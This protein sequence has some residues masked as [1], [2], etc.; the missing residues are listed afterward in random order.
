MIMTDRLQTANLIDKFIEVRKGSGN[1]SF[2]YI[3]HL[4]ELKFIRKK[5]KI[6]FYR[7]PMDVLLKDNLFSSCETVTLKFDTNL[8]AYDEYRRI[9]KALCS[10]LDKKTTSN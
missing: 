3:Y 8:E 9:H 6:Y 2:V 5:V 4:I 10:I 7:S 1:F